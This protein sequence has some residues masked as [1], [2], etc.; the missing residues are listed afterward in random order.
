MST[1]ICLIR[2]GETNWNRTSRFQGQSDPP[3]NDTGRTQAEAMARQAAAYDFSALYSSDL[4]RAVTTAEALQR[5]T[6]LPLRRLPELRERHF[7]IFQ[8]LQKDAAARQFPEVYARYKKRDLSCDFGHGESLAAFSRRVMEVF[9]WLARQHP[10]QRIAVISH[11]GVLDI[12]Y[13]HAL[14]KTLS[15]PRN[16]RITHC[17]L[18]WISGDGRH[19]AIEHWEETDSHFRQSGAQR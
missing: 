15:E 14:G 2:H 8:G 19:W 3:L 12:I 9:A 6:A 17:T 11:A 10:Q 7:G 18:N 5:H 13:R 1:R 16:R 4:Q